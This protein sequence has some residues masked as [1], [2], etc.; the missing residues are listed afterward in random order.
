MSSDIFA[1]LRD[2]ESPI[3]MIVL[4]VGDLGDGVHLY[5]IGGAFF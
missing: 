5:V 3:L 2:H 4:V 1:G